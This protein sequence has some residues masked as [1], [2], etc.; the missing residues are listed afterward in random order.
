MDGSASLRSD[1]L[2][3]LSPQLKGVALGYPPDRPLG[4]AELEAFVHKALPATPFILIAESFSGPLAIS[5]AA[6]KP[7]GLLGVVLVC[8]FARSPVRIP[9]AL[10][11][12]ASWLPVKLIPVHVVAAALLGRYASQPLKTRLSAA[13]APVRRRVW[14]ARVQ[15]VVRVDVTARLSAITVPLLYIRATE[16]RLLGRGAFEIIKQR[17]PEVQLASIDGPHM[18]LQAKPDEVAMQVRAFAKKLIHLQ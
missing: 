16:D 7:A 11:E 15:A 1:F 18:L 12:I 9:Q 10:R 8:S 3:S 2:A 6:A 13:L 17:V 14:R 4:Y 5:L